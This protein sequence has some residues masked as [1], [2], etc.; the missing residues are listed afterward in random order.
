ME[1][2]LS[3]ATLDSVVK[4]RHDGDREL[5][6]QGLGNMVAACFGSVPSTG[7]PARGLAS[8]N[9]GGR[10]RRAGMIHS[11]I[12]FAALMWGNF[13]LTVIPY[14]VMAGIMIMIGLSLTDAWIIRLLRKGG[15]AFLSD[16]LIVVAV[17]G[18]SL[19]VDLAVAVVVG[20][21]FAVILF[22]YRMSRS[23]VRRVFDRSLGK[24]RRIRSVGVEDVLAE[25]SNRIIVIELDGPIFFGTSAFLREE[26]TRVVRTRPR[27]VILNAAAVSHIDLSGIRI[28]QDIGRSYLAD[29]CDV[30]ISGIYPNAGRIKWLRKTGLSDF[31]PEHNWF[32]SMTLAM[33]AAENLIVSER[34]MDVAAPVQ[35]A[36]MDFVKGMSPLVVDIIRGFLERKHFDWVTYSSSWGIQETVCILS[37]P[38]LPTSY[39]RRR[40]GVG[41]FGWR[42]SVRAPSSAK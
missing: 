19:F 12:L 20:V 14:S 22:F 37:W 7:A 18:V 34:G 9:V 11:L 21:A 41:R 40:R 42:P 31:I 10:S 30:F 2:L 28:L 38:A 26:F 23:I 5:V 29:G 33:E 13:V 4:S 6:G 36:E 35:L 39:C 17:A 8:Y 25:E 15:R 1:S 27:V 3:A 16:F 32:A 24:S